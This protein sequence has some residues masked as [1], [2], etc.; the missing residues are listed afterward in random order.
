MRFASSSM[1]LLPKIS[2]VTPV[3][4]GGTYL[5]ET[6]ESVLRQDYPNL[7]YIVVDGGSTDGTL[8]IIARYEAREDFPQRIGRVIS[9]PDQGMYDALAKGFRHASGEI[10]C[11]LNADDLFEPH[12]LR[13]V[14]EFFLQHRE[15]SVIY[16]EDIVLVDGWKYPN[17]RQP[18]NVDTISLLNGHI[19]F[20]D[21]V[22][23]RRAAFEA[24]GGMRRD[25][26]LAGD[27]DLWLRL[28]D[29]FRFVRR[30]GHVSCFR[31]RPGQLSNQR[32][33]YHAEMRRSIKNFIAAAS[34]TKRLLWGVQKGVRR[35]AR[36]WFARSNRERLFFP[37]DFRNF[38]P[39]TASVPPGAAEVPCSPIALW[40][41]DIAVQ[42]GFEKVRK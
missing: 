23:W 18:A 41:S 15:V 19:L 27:F 17:V 38:P 24:I 29:Q 6:L 1:T 33:L 35:A 9:E 32:E 25:F 31:M 12:A 14:G 8:D 36:V 11:Y 42:Y 30:P 40:V 20:Q 13:S 37:I 2:V 22:F 26:R 16:H 10:Y 28:S 21:G 7:E 5:A 3:F 39:P 4:N 34:L